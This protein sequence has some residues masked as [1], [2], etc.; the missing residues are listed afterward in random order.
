MTPPPPRPRPTTTATAARNIIAVIGS[1]GVG[2]SQYAV[3]LANASALR[4]QQ[5]RS[6]NNTNEADDDN[7]SKK[8]PHPTPRI[9]PV[10]LSADAM[11]LYQGLPVITNKVTPEEQ[12]GVEH[13]GLGVVR[14]AGEGKG[15]GEGEG[16][17]VGG[18]WEVGK[19]CGEAWGKLERAREGGRE[20]GRESVQS[21]REKS[22]MTER[23]LKSGKSGK[24]VEEVKRKERARRADALGGRLRLTG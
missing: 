7:S 18:S 10:I 16:E 8:I 13:W 1:T 22:V 21:E 14:L 11:Q 24:S 19:W 23:A 20:G 12:A 2:K 6:H 3:S 15:E 4:Q 17:G 5:Q 9:R